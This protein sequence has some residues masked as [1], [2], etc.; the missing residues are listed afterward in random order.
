[1]GVYRV[2]DVIGTSAQSGEDAAATAVKTASQTLRDLRVAEVVEQDLHIEEEA[3]RLS[4]A[5]SSGSPSSTTSGTHTQ[6]SRTASER[7]I[8]ISAGSARTSPGPGAA[9]ARHAGCVPAGVR[10]TRGA[11]AR[12]GEEPAQDECRQA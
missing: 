9:D 4:S 3:A 1:M 5:P 8:R 10:V 12:S 11:C 2:I 6:T 7:L